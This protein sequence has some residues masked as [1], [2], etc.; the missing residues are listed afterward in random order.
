MAVK[1]FENELLIVEISIQNVPHT[2]RMQ[3]HNYKIMR[4]ICTVFSNGMRAAQYG[5]GV[6]SYKQASS[7]L[8]Y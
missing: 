8:Q 3:V 1:L 2:I 7:D 6:L 5:S 4:N